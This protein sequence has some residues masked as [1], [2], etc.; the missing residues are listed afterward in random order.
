MHSSVIQKRNWIFRRRLLPGQWR[1]YTSE[2]FTTLWPTANST[3]H[4]QSSKTSLTFASVATLL[5]AVLSVTATLTSFLLKT[6][7]TVSFSIACIVNFLFGF[8]RS[9]FVGN[10]VW[11][12][13]AWRISMRISCFGFFIWLINAE[14][15][16]EICI[17]GVELYFIPKNAAEV[18]AKRC[19]LYCFVSLVLLN[20]RSVFFIRSSCGI[21]FDICFHGE[22]I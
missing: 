4:S 16:T 19:I 1:R 22:F 3:K 20:F 15:E 2:T 12:L 14:F 18:L 13:F 17:Y 10:S 5:R 21:Q 11:H 8:L 7:Y 6:V 9:N